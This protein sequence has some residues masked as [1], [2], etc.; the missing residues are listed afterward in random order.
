MNINLQRNIKSITL[1]ILVFL[2][3]ILLIN[4]NNNPNP[5]VQR[6]F[7]PIH[8]R[9]GTTI[10]YAG[11]IPAFLVY[12]CLIGLYRQNNYA[13][14]NTR[15]KRVII[16]IIIFSIFSKYSEYGIKFYKSFYNNLNSIYCYRENSNINTWTSDKKAHVVFRVELE[17]C[18]SK[19]Q[20]F[21]VKVNLP[22]YLKEIDR[23]SSVRDKMV[24]LNAHEK[25]QFEITLYEG[26]TNSNFYYNKFEF[27]LY[28][29]AQEVKFKQVD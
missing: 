9:T 14:L 11:L 10:F 15:F 23:I 24:T 7:K 17:N 3:L 22:N 21:Y 18:S 26:N 12:C 20:E 16:L 27:S 13:I 2:G 28:N 6:I 29:S 19:T 8:I 25:R 5:L 4:T 1:I